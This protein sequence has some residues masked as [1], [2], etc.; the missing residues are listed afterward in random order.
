LLAWTQLDWAQPDQRITPGE[1]KEMIVRFVSSAEGAK[2]G[3]RDIGG[4]PFRPDSTYTA[5][6]DPRNGLIRLRGWRV[7]PARR[8]VAV[9]MGNTEVR[10][11]FVKDRDRFVIKDA[12]EVEVARIK[13]EAAKAMILRFLSSAQAA[14]LPSWVAESRRDV[15][16]SGPSF[17]TCIGFRADRVILGRWSVDPYMETVVL[18]TDH[19]QLSGTV[20]RDGENYVI[21]DVA[22]TEVRRITPPEAKAMILRFISTPQADTLPQLPKLREIVESAKPIALRDG[23]ICVGP[24]AIDSMTQDV[25]LTV[26]RFRDLYGVF[27]KE[28]E[29]YSIF[30]TGEIEIRRKPR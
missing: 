9:P 21:K 6:F 11:S 14:A 24:W 17:R 26:S 20:G 4:G 3:F 23:S 12:R 19:A 1:A 29:T 13:P 25:H 15:E 28:G 30:F 10:G 16:S 22:V 18:P 7:D 2:L 27:V 8:T 5:Y